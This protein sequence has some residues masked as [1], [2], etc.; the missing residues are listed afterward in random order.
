MKKHFFNFVFIVTTFVFIG[1]LPSCDVGE[2]NSNTVISDSS[3]NTVTHRDTAMPHEPVKAVVAAT[4][5]LTPSAKNS[6][7]DSIGSKIS[8]QHGK[9]KVVDTIKKDK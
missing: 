6:T 1:L 7:I 9:V 2:G 3:A 8:I 4:D 5:S